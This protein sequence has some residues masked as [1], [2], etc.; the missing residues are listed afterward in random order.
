MLSFMLVLRLCPAAVG[1]AALLVAS[2]VT[3]QT[4]IASTVH[5][6]TPGGPGQL[7]ETRPT[8]LCVYCHTPHNANPTQALWN[9]DTPATT[10][11]LYTSSTMQ[12]IPNQPSGSSRLCLSCHDGILALGNLRVPPPGEDLKLGP[13]SGNRL[14]GTDLSDDHPIS[15]VYDA[16]LA[17]RRGELADPSGLPQTVRLDASQ[18]LQCTTCHD[19]HEDRRPMFLRMANT[20]GVL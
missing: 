2:P 16:E 10:Y 4:Q 12:A 11:Q 7:K 19:P 18:Q 6:L 9:R 8:G 20:D 14:L 3:A 15:F 1:L 17:V 5:N 13:M